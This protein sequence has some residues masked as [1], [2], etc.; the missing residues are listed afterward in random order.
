MSYG[1]TCEF[2]RALWSSLVQNRKS[3][4]VFTQNII[5]TKFIKVWPK[6]LA[7]WEEVDASL[8]LSAGEVWTIIT[9]LTGV[10]V[11]FAIDTYCWVL[12]GKIAA[13]RYGTVSISYSNWFDTD[14]RNGRR[15]HVIR[16][17]LPVSLHC[18]EYHYGI[19][20]IEIWNLR[21]IHFRVYLWSITISLVYVCCNRTSK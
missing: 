16:T 20:S 9:L 5:T 6:F 13:E 17:V 14:V 1:S 4:K 12:F 19:G 8:D 2:R 18:S 10:S 7:G 3:I 15:S 11:E 21:I